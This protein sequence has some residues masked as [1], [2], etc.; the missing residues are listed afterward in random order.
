MEHDKLRAFDER[1]GEFLSKHGVWTHKTESGYFCP[2]CKAKH[3]ESPMMDVGNAA[4][5]PICQYTA[6]NPDYKPPPP[7]VPR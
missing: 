6:A 7:K 3:I 1:F 4:M 2:P 5:C